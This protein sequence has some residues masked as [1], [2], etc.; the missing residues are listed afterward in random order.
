MTKEQ[1]PS[2]SLRFV[3]GTRGRDGRYGPQSKDM[4]LS[5]LIDVFKPED[6]PLHSL[7]KVIFPDLSALARKMDAQLREHFNR[8]RDEELAQNY[9]VLFNT[10][11]QAG[12]IA[13]ISNRSRRWE[14]VMDLSM[15]Y[16]LLA[17]KRMPEPARFWPMR[18]DCV[19]E[20]ATKGKMYCEALLFHIIARSAFDQGSLANDVTLRGYCHWLKDW[21]KGYIGPYEYKSLL[22]CAAVEKM[23]YFEVLQFLSGNNEHLDARA[24]LI[25]NLSEPERANNYHLGDEN[26]PVNMTCHLKFDNHPDISWKMIEVLRDLHYR[27]ARIENFLGIL[28]DRGENVDFTQTYETSAVMEEFISQIE[29]RYAVMIE[30]HPETN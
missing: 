4:S 5:D 3:I 27:V 26:F 12:S 20:V 14:K 23:E 9:D 18:E 13:D 6:A 8:F 21:L 29:A 17:Q 28:E 11:T 24:F 16:I 7:N 25:S 30:E 10:W 15:G 1:N 2:E 22:L 19:N